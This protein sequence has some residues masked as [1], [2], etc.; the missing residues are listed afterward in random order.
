[1]SRFT[2]R[3]SG[4]TLTLTQ[5]I[6]LRDGLDSGYSRI[7]L[8]QVRGGTSADRIIGVYRDSLVCMTRGGKSMANK[9]TFFIAQDLNT[10]HLATHLERWLDS[11]GF[12]FQR[13]QERNTL[14]IQARKGGAWRNVVGMSSA[15]TVKLENKGRNLDVEIG[16]AKWIDKAGAGIFWTIVFW[17]VALTSVYGAYDQ[18]KLPSR[19]FGE[20]EQYVNVWNARTTMGTTP[21]AILQQSAGIPDSMRECPHCQENISSS[22]RFCEHC[23]E[24]TGFDL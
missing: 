17:P 3:I 5:L 20:I 21:K 22:A 13:L 16:A 11:E 8:E 2:R 24:G 6:R 12:E 9:R 15:L 23:G 1:M 7:L 14:A 18:M 4:I 19:I 10:N